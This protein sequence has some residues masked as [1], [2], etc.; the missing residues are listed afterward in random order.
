[1]LQP[2][3]QGAPVHYCER[4]LSGTNADA[5]CLKA[6]MLPEADVEAGATAG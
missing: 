5:S 1:M 2:D 6:E 3:C 4:R